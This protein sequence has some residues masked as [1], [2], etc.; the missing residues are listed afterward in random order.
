MPPFES[1]VPSFDFNQSTVFG[2]LKGKKRVIEAGK[3]V[4][5]HVSELTMYINLLHSLS[6]L[7]EV[8]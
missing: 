3:L 6:N 8:E 2:T 5:L 1:T 7:R 4:F